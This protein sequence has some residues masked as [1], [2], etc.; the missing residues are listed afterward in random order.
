[1]IALPGGVDGSSGGPPPG[2]L[3]GV[4]VG[5]GD[6]E[7]ISLKGY[8]LL[9]RVPFVFVPVQE[10]GTESIARRIA[11]PFLDPARQSIVQLPFAMRGG[12]RRREDRWQ[13][14]A[15]AIGDVLRDGQDAAFLTE[16]D[17][18]LYSTFIHV[19]GALSRLWPEVPVV[20]VPA[21]SSFQAAAALVLLP[22]ADGRE[23]LAVLPAT[24]G[25]EELRRT[26]LSFHTTVILKVSAA[27]DTVLQVLDETGLTS[28]TICV[29]RCGWAEQEIVGDVSTLRGRRLDYFSLFIV[30]TPE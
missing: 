1:M 6:P 17:P 23:R 2:T 27:L 5:P 3:Y 15:A 30:R 10:D 9:Q 11:E 18:M 8:R 28:S 25:I 7:L 22:L 16:G 13:A 29:S 14:H 21:V 26:V 24:A 4:G 20:A 12:E 19:A